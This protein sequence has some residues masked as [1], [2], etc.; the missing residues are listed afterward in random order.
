[1]SEQYTYLE[2][3]DIITETEMAIAVENAPSSEERA[4]KCQK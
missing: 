3:S 1:M 4:S 2:T